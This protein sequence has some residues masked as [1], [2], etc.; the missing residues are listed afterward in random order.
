MNTIVMRRTIAVTMFAML[1]TGT[2]AIAQPVVKTVP[3]QEP[4]RW[5][6]EDV[7]V[8]QKMS[9]ARK[10]AVNGQQYSLDACKELPLPQ[11]QA[12]VKE[13]RMNYQ[14]DLNAMNMRFGQ[15]Q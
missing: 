13:A 15:T 11:Q 1:A 7:T 9:T 5:T 2:A 6:Q 4:A 14:K 8:A 10:E 12:C 3:M